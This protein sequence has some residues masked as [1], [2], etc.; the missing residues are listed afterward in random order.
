MG[1]GEFAVPV[2]VSRLEAPGAFKFRV[3][4]KKGVEN[5]ITLQ[6]SYID[7]LLQSLRDKGVPI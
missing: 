5:V 6:R 2:A 3:N 7:G 1:R 4:S